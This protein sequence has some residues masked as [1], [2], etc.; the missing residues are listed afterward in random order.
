MSKRTNYKLHSRITMTLLV[1]AIASSISYVSFMIFTLDRLEAAMLATLLGHELDEQLVELSLNPDVRMPDTASVKG[2][3]L[4]RERQRPIPEYL[5]NLSSDVH[6]KLRVGDRIYQIA[7]VDLPNDRLFLSFDVTAMS[8][9]RSILQILLIGGALLTTIVLVISGFWLFRKFLLPVSQLAHE[10]SAIDPNQRD[11]RIEDKYRDYEVGMIARAIDQFL[12]RVDSF[13]EREQSFTAAVS[14]ELRTPISVISTATDLLELEGLADKQQRVVNRI[15]DSTGYMRNVIEALLFFAR[16]THR[17]VEITLPEIKL[18]RVISRVMKNYQ[19]AA[20]NKKLK[21]RFVAQAR[22]RVRMVESHLEIILGNLIRNAISNTT[23]GEICVTLFDDGF[24]VRDTGRGIDAD[25]IE[26]IVKL[27][28]RS[29]D[30]PGHGLGLYLVKSICDIYGLEL[31][32]ESSLG[33]GSEFRIIFP[34]SM[35]EE[36]SGQKPAH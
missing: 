1:I 9:N 19:E 7:V 30:S 27:N 25:E 22:I 2:Y 33:K 32:I 16:D 6:H 3:L 8:S 31:E 35:L 13:V 34:D 29:P 10:V 5:R 23:T 18:H 26:L 17:K 24:S 21:L 12:A 36:A 20:A 15:K 28:Y 14:H 11:L 4:S